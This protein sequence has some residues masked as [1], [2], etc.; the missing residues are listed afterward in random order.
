MKKGGWFQDHSRH[1]LAAKGISTAQAQVTCRRLSGES[2]EDLYDRQ[3]AQVEDLL[4]KYKSSKRASYKIAVKKEIY[5]LAKSPL[6]IEAV[7]IVEQ[8]EKSLYQEIDKEQGWV[9]YEL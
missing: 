4:D 2:N 9:T 3:I 1:S 5:E 6:P 7:R 8:R